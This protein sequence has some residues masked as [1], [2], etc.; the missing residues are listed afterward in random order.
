MQRNKVSLKDAA[1]A[2]P[3]FFV[4]TRLGGVKV[5][6]AICNFQTNGCANFVEMARGSALTISSMTTGETSNAASKVRGVASGL[7]TTVVYDRK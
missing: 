6:E 2:V 4:Q 7:I 5:V 1:K 3:D